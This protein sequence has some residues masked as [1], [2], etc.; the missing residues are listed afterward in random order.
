MTRESFII[1]SKEYAASKIPAF[2]ANLLA[3]KLQKIIL[4]AVASMA[5]NG[6]GKSIMDIDLSSAAS[7]ISENLNESVM[8]DIVMPMF[9]LANVASVTD[10]VK[11]DSEIN[12]NKVFSD[13]SGLA[14]FYELVFLVLKYN[15]GNFLASLANRFGGNGGAA[16]NS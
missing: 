11:I 5:G 6:Q 7:I 8:N 4:P 15:F 12:F 10:N 3:L 13:D 9:K 1:G 14:D 2:Q 16:T